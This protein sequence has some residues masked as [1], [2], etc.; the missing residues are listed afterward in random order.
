L[1]FSAYLSGHIDTFRDENSKALL[2]VK[3]MQTGSGSV[4]ISLDPVVSS[5]S[6]RTYVPPKGVSTTLRLAISEPV[7][8][9]CDE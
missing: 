1:F 4:K 8:V 7:Q 6:G 2:C 9:I 3:A 5:V